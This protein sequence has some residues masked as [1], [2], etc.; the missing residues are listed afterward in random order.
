MSIWMS[1]SSSPNRNSARAFDSSVLPTPDGPAKMNEPEGRFGSFRPA[2]VRRMARDT[3][4]TASFWPMMRLCSSSSMR[5]RREDSSSVSLKTGMPVQAA[6]TSAICSS[7][8]SV[9]VS[10][11]PSRH[12]CSFSRR[13]SP[14]LR[15]L[16]RRPAAFSKSWASMAASFSRRTS[17]IRPSISC[18]SAGAVMRLMRMRAPA[19]SMRSTALSGRKRS[20]M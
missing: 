1:E 6:S 18:R 13:S 4:C 12:F 16:S 3:A 10:V 7:P 14:S 8:T 11:S 9:M 20:L 15:S 17:A 5:S 19:S 2:R